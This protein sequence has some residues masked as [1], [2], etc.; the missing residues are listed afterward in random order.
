M[1]SR[2]E[3]IRKKR[4]QRGRPCKEDVARTESGRISYA[5]GAG[6]A[7][8]VLARRKRVEMFG[9][10]L[11]DAGMQNA[12]SFIGRMFIARE[13]NDAQHRALYR[14]GEDHARYM[15][16]MQVPDSLR[17]KSGGSVMRISN[18]EAD[19]Q[20]RSRWREVQ[21]S[22]TD[23]QSHHNGNLLAAL[24]FMVIRD[25]FHEHM[26]GDLRIA[27]NVLVRHYGIS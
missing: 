11:K 4:Q 8:D 1:T 10:K 9:V 17:T 5:K 2:A 6:E 3:R 16:V 27:A 26:V 25:Q 23:A 15:S 12:G 7:P 22:I 18:D 21:R 24:Q 19:V 13:I 14:Y 20:T